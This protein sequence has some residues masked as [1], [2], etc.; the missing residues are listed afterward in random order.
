MK[1]KKDKVICFSTTA[2]QYEALMKLAP[3]K[4]SMSSLLRDIIQHYLDSKKPT[5]Q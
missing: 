3:F 4:D 2:S 5:Q 1:E